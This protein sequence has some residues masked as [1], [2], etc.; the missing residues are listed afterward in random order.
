MSI[1][2]YRL[3]VGDARDQLA[4][5]PTASVQCIITSPPYY[6]LRSYLGDD[7]PDKGHEI[8]AEKTPADYVQSLTGVFHEAYRVLKSD[9]L[10][11]INIDDSYSRGKRATDPHDARRGQ[12]IG[13]KHRRTT[14][15]DGYGGGGAADRLAK[16]LL[17]IPWRVALALQDDGWILRSDI[18]WCLSGGTFVYVRHQ[19]GDSPMM[20]KDLARLDPNTVQLWNGA[21]WTRLL[22]VSKSERRGDE[23]MFVLRSGERIACTPT[24]R[25]PTNRGIVSAS[26]IA[27]GDRL[28]RV[29]LPEP[30]EP[31]DSVHVGTDAAWFAGL[32]LAEGSMSGDTIQIT[33]HAKKQER[34][35]RVLRIAKD[36]GGTATRTVQGNCMDIRVYGKMLVALIRQLVAGKTA[37]DKSIAPVCWRYSNEFLRAYLDGYLSGDGH[38][39]EKDNRWRLRFMRNYNLERDLRVLAARLGFRLTLNF[40]HST[41]D[42]KQWPAFVGEIR[43]TRSGHGNEKCMEEVVRIE[44]ARSRHMYDLGVEDEPHLF[45][46][47]SGI[48][49]HNSQPNPFPESVLDRPTRSHEYVFMLAKSNRPQFWVHA[50]RPYMDQIRHKPQ[51][52]WVWVHRKTGQVRRDDPHD[53]THWRRKNLWRA[54]NYYYD[55]AAIA[56]PASTGDNGSYFDRGKTAAAHPGRSPDIRNKQEHWLRNKRDVWSIATAGAASPDGHFAVFP[57]KLVEP[58]ILAGSRPGDVI[59]DPFA[60]SGTTLA[61]AN[62]LGR[63][64]W[65]IELAPAYADLI[66]HRLSGQLTWAI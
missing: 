23:M 44:K 45:A 18:I 29:V 46:L 28:Q 15:A 3:W 19:K 64:A 21:K 27:I 66:H 5:L 17:G 48:L 6:N 50:E 63:M 9:G 47:G 2:S 41:Y 31:K 16:N 13:S 8:G 11:F 10:L 37:R 60:G 30:D 39:D 25:F 54:C 61:A 49:T 24:H 33:G 34:W 55:A 20:I 26:E 4:Q 12:N 22:G 1:A 42:G 52:D 38:W 35:D 62:R 57:E 53:P 56:E 65:G 14:I 40:G 32:Y 43:F 59:L 51:P 7:D 58:M 36:Y